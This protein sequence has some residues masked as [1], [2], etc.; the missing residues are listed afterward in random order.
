MP[1]MLPHDGK[2]CACQIFD[3]KFQIKSTSTR[4][5]SKKKYTNIF[6]NNFSLRWFFFRCFPPP[7]VQLPLSCYEIVWL[8]GSTAGGQLHFCT[9][10]LRFCTSNSIF[11]VPVRNSRYSTLI[12]SDLHRITFFIT[13]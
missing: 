2:H 11:G 8:T 7:F 6:L 9:Y 1:M 12:V 13:R 4:G 3:Q 10:M 5:H